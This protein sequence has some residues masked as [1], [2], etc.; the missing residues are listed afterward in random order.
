[1]ICTS[2]VP[3]LSSSLAK[4]NKIIPMFVLFSG[5]FG[6]FE[7]LAFFRIKGGTNLAPERPKKMLS[8]NF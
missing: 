5:F 3:Y 7:S 8:V 4:N 6:H 1:M 2:V